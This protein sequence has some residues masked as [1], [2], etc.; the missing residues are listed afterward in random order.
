VLS[1]NKIQGSFQC[2]SRQ[3][4]LLLELTI[5]AHRSFLHDLDLKLETVV[6]KC[7]LQGK[8]ARFFMLHDTK[9]GKNVPNENKT[10]IKYPKFK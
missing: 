5:L 3:F 8:V 10:V 1:R 9:T 4:W 7:D 6:R 2:W